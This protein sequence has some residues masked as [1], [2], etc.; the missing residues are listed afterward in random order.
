MFCGSS[1][2]CQQRKNLHWSG[3]VLSLREH[4]L[5]RHGGSERPRGSLL[6]QHNLDPGTR[7]YALLVDVLRR[8]VVAP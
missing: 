8:L 6:K 4:S 1:V 5:Q 3:P 2:E 7:I